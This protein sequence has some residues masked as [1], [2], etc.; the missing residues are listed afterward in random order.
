V[1]I[2]MQRAHSLSW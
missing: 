2:F 1:N